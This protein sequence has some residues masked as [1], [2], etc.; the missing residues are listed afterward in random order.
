MGKKAED[1]PL[2]PAPLRRKAPQDVR[3]TAWFQFRQEIMELEESGRYE[4]AIDTLNGIAESVEK[5]QMVTLGQ[6]RAVENIRAA[7]E[8]RGYGSRRYEGFRKRNR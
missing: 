4:W 6:R 2:D 3:D 7:G 5:Y 8:R 1:L